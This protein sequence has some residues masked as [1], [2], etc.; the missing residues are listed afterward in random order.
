MHTSFAFEQVQT[1]SLG[2]RNLPPHG[3]KQN[4]RQPQSLFSISM[5]HTHTIDVFLVMILINIIVKL[6]YSHS[7]IL[8]N[9]M[10]GNHNLLSISMI[11]THDS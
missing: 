11:R 5:G 8:L 10:A 4:G 7:K 2:A 6:F 3:V 9:Q 1:I